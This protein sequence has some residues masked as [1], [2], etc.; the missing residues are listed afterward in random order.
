MIIKEFFA[1]FAVLIGYFIVCASLALLIRK[2]IKMQR[3]LFRKTLHTILLCSLFVWVY[4]FSTWWLSALAVALF[5]AVVY[6]VLALAE[7]IRGYSELLTERKQGEI[8]KSLL[9]VFTMFAAVI[10][11]C[12]GWMGDKMLFIACVFAWGFGD[13]AAALVGKRFGKH[14]L[15]GRFIEGRKSVEGTLAMFA[16]SFVSVLIVL[17]LR[18][19]ML[20]Y[21][22]APTA[23][24]AAGVCAAVELYTP[25]GFDTITC[26]FAAAAVILPLTYLWGGIV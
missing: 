15:E 17:L 2:Y 1:G 19:N 16:V 14:Y 21:G 13:G 22:Y 26:P 7:R 25:G 4:A 6:P 18:G 10:C 12:W 3:E 20:W 5:A 23:L 9:V 8:K 24:L 11:V